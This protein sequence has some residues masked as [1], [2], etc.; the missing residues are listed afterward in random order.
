MKEFLVTIR[1][2]LDVKFFTVRAACAVDALL[3]IAD[4]IPHHVDAKV[5]VTP[6]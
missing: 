1:T 2:A 4:R 6:A 3:A 5:K